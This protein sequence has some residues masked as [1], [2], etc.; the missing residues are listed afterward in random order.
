MTNRLQRLD[1]IAD[2]LEDHHHR[3]MPVRTRR[4]SETDG[5]ATS[6]LIRNGTAKRAH[7]ARSY[8]RWK[9]RAL[10][11]LV[12]IAALAT[13]VSLSLLAAHLML[14]LLMV[15][16]ERGIV[17]FDDALAATPIHGGR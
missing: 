4:T 12:F 7:H 10:E 6:L 9:G 2:D 15:V 3:H 14:M 5:L 17:A 16:M 13:S 8:T 11:L 1:V